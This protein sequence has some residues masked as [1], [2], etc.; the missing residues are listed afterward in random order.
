M[1]ARKHV[2]NVPIASCDLSVIKILVCF[3]RL[4]VQLFL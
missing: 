3:E 4:A 1:C 2:G